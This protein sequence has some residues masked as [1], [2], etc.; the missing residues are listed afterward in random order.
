MNFPLSP[1]VLRNILNLILVQM[2]ML[3]FS[4]QSSSNIINNIENGSNSVLSINTTVLM[5]TNNQSTK[6]SK[7]MAN[8][9]DS[10]EWA[11]IQFTILPVLSLFIGCIGIIGNCL[12]F[13]VLHAYPT[14][15]VTFGGECTARVNLL[16]LAL[17]DF[18][19]CLTSLPLGYV[20]RRYTSHNFM[21]YYTIYG[22][23]LVTY[24][25]TV[26]VWMV[27]LMS[28]VRYLVVCR[29]LASR[30][31]L[32]S[33]HMLHIITLLYLL[34][35]LFH[36]P[37]FLTYTYSEE[38][39]S[40]KRML[41]STIQ[42]SEQQ[43]HRRSYPTN[44]SRT[45][46]NKTEKHNPVTIFVIE[47]EIWKTESIRIA[48]T[49]SQIILTNIGPFIGVVI[50]NVS[51][52]RAC[53][54]SDAC[55]K[56]YTYDSHKTFEKCNNNNVTQEHSSTQTRLQKRYLH[57]FQRDSNNTH[58]QHVGTGSWRTNS[59]G[60]SSAQRLQQRA[61]NRVTPLLLA[62]II[63]FLLFTAP[64]G[65]VH[66]ACLQ[67]M[68]EM[69]SLVRHDRN[70]RILYMTL[71]LTVEWTN[72]VQLLGCASN[73]F[74]YFLVSTTFRRTTKRLSQRF[75]RNVREYKCPNILKILCS[76]SKDSSWNS[77]TRTNELRRKLADNLDKQFHP[78]VVPTSNCQHNE[79]QCK[80]GHTSNTNNNQIIIYNNNN[81]NENDKRI[82]NS[83]K[84]QFCRLNRK[85]SKSTQS[86]TLNTKSPN[87][88][89]PLCCINDDFLGIHTSPMP[90][91]NSSI[92]DKIS[93]N[94][95]GFHEAHYKYLMN[96]SILA[97]SLR[98]LAI[99]P[100][101]AHV[102][103]GYASLPESKSCLLKPCSSTS[104][105]NNTHCLNNTTTNTSE[106]LGIIPLVS[107][108]RNIYKHYGN[109]N[110]SV[111]NVNKITVE[112]DNMN[113]E[114]TNNS[115]S[116]PVQRASN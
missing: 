52:I 80:L 16:G 45:H 3:S 106:T 72:V 115:Y 87:I 60:K 114:Q 4:S 5:K 59:Q 76:D 112:N 65:I 67:V 100:K 105:K 24:F 55:R 97:S 13:L 91:I 75:Y 83:V 84:L 48:Y 53:R 86:Q 109:L 78:Q 21:L 61:T 25:L 26:S 7:S 58:Q 8:T 93:C 57:Y 19:V 40:H 104:S 81:S 62:V 35:L 88:I 1:R 92:S 70:A 74:L 99:C 82:R 79:N 9:T 94:C 22:P 113:S 17:A 28:I 63:A 90:C 18:L 107:D 71:N 30:A 64:F 15:Q 51:V 20:Q 29:P 69:G 102:V 44:T 77:D 23:G 85:R 56:S 42:Q 103:G 73:F 12:N 11:R 27:L 68:S 98:G 46:F 14:S 31:C 43:T 10:L 36:I 2:I 34:A 101:C 108:E 110:Y 116:L 111:N 66:F 41:N 32:T 95:V 47:R 33:R 96:T 37:S 38:K 89:N 54:Q 39:V 50:T 6:S 49:V